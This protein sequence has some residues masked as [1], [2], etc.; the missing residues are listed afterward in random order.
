MKIILRNILSSL[1]GYFLVGIFSTEETSTENRKI[2]VSSPGIFGGLR[3]LPVIFASSDITQKHSDNH[4]KM[5]RIYEI[6]GTVRKYSIHFY[7]NCKSVNLYCY[8]I[9]CSF[10]FLWKA[11]GTSSRRRE[12]GKSSNRK[13]A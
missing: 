2:F 4:Y 5:F 1:F 7:N 10:L 6:F 8:I 12:G 11:F 13:I 9:F 3:K